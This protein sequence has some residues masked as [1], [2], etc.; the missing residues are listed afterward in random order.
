MTD[1]A[2]D[3]EHRENMAELDRK[4][5]VQG[6]CDAGCPFCEIEALAEG[7]PKEDLPCG[8]GDD[9][10]FSHIPGCPKAEGQP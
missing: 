5:H 8:C 3:L 6:I 9:G 2:D 4:E 10:R 7:Q 1:A